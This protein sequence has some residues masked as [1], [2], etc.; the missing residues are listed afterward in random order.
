M[1][2]LIPLAGE[3]RADDTRILVSTGIFIKR[4]STEYKRDRRSDGDVIAAAVSV[5]ESGRFNGE[6]AASCFVYIRN[7]YGRL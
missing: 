2:A 1:V 6:I 5:A 4:T 7:K 3:A